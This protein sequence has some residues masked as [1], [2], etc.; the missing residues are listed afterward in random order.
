MPEAEDNVLIQ[1]QEAEWAMLLVPNHW[2]ITHENKDHAQPA[3]PP[4]MQR[5]DVDE[6][7]SRV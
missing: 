3:R 5:T 6:V 7:L 2:I 1:D 4:S